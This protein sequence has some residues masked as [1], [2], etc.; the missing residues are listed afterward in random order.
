VNE[1][2]RIARELHDTLLQSFQGL[3]LRFQSA[4]DLLPGE[5]A[6]AVEALEG[7]LNRADQALVEGRDAIQNL[8]S[9]TIAGNELAHAIA[10]LAQELTDSPGSGRRSPTF[11]MSVAGPPRDLHPIVRDHVHHIAREALRNAFRHAEADLIEVEVTYGAREMRLRVRD[12]GK[13]MDAQHLSAGRA[14]HWG[15]TTMRER[16][17]QTGAQ[18]HL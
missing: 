14:R 8:R 11:R 7:A 17:G 2:T 18:L 1:R 12:D 4:R 5:P 10:T 13:G 16:A 15:L 3:M 9:S 6:R